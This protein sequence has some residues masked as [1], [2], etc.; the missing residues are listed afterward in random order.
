M[1][2]IFDGY[3]VNLHLDEDNE[4]LACFSEMPNVSA[5][6][7]TPE[8]ALRELERAWELMK[9]DYIVSGEEVPVAP[10]RKQYSGTFN[11]RVD[12]RLHR[13]LAMEAA[14]S[15]ISLNALIAKKLTEAAKGL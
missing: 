10:S 8:E 9:E 3:T 5:A 4:Y 11:V 7:A 2:D 1:K 13:N 15:G 6:G 14:R 12:K